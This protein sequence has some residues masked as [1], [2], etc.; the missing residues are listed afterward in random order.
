MKCTI[1]QG[2]Y[3]RSSISS[4]GPPTAPPSKKRNTTALWKWMLPLMRRKLKLSVGRGENNRQSEKRKCP[5]ASGNIPPQPESVG[6]CRAFFRAYFGP[7]K[8]M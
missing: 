8:W 6:F 7:T 2:K 5:V 4:F 3:A 1:W